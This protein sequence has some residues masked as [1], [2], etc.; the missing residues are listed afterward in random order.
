M[1]YFTFQ[2]FYKIL[3]SFNKYVKTSLFLQYLS[4][5]FMHVTLVENTENFPYLGVNKNEIISFII[6]ESNLP[7]NKYEPIAYEGVLH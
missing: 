6:L 5:D 1:F 4:S 7:V 2:F 3:C